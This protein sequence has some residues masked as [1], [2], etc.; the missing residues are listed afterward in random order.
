MLSYILTSSA[1]EAKEVGVGSTGTRVRPATGGDVGMLVELSAALFREDAGTRDSS[2]NVG[3]PLEYGRGYFAG[4]VGREDVV[5]LLADTGGITVGYLAGYVHEPDV[6]RP[7]SVAVLESMYVREGARGV[8]VGGKLVGAFLDRAGKRGAERASVT[9]YSANERA[10]RF[11]ER[12]GFRP[13]S[14]TLELGLGW[15]GSVA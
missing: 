3:W 6:L 5:C 1:G 2:T 7:V 13:R 4:F 14:V 12:H 15:P 11:Y 8:G 10:I 9:A